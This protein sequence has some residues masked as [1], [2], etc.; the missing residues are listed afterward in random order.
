MWRI[1]A[2]D[3]GTSGLFFFFFRGLP[4][5]IFINIILHMTLDY[6]QCAMRAQTMEKEEHYRTVNSMPQRQAENQR[7]TR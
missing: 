6:Q 5:F 3:H 1:V 7:F 2:H 4:D